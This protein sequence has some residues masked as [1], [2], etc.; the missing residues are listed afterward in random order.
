[1][2]EDTGAQVTDVLARRPLGRTGLEVTPVCLGG[3]VLGSMPEVFGYAVAAD[4]GIATVRRA[5]AGPINFL[6]TS[7][8]YSGGESER[9]I[10]AALRANGGLPAGYVLATKADPIGGDF[11]GDAV[12]RSVAGSLQR[13]GLDRLQLV[14]L[15]D[16]ER[17]S[18]ADG[19]A[20][21]GPVEALVDLQRQGVIEHLG[22]A[23]GPIPLLRQYLRSGAFQVVLTH[24]RF[25]L[26]DQSAE[27]LIDE[28]AAL[29]VGVLNAA[30][31]GGG[32]LAKGPDVQPNYAYQQADPERV[33][34]V[35]D[36]EDH[37]GRFGVPLRAAALQFSIRD[38]RIGSTVVG[39]SSPERVDDTIGLAR[40]PIPGELW[41]LINATRGAQ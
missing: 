38:P 32:F 41:D 7:A 40:W 37:C 14:H 36:I 5:L 28:A 30:P 25:T 27:P 2:G 26:V 34:L 20:A 18:F 21:G 29:G 4:Q 12:R 1:M 24:N 8:D 19:M 23:G 10:G 31:Y 22:V 9:R 16:P 15:H 35:R 17:I 13:L 39:V 33:Q 3:G 6:D 11:S